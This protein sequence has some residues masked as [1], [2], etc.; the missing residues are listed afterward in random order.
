MHRITYHQPFDFERSW[1]VHCRSEEGQCDSSG[2]FA[3]WNEGRPVIVTLRQSRR[4]G[5]IEVELEPEPA[6]PRV[7]LN[8]IRS[9]LNAD[10]DLEAFYR[11]ARRDALMR[12]VT[13]QLRGLKPIRPADLFQMMVIAITEQ[14]ISMAAA[15]RIRER[16]VHRFGTRVKDL[17]AFPQPSDFAGCRIDDLK[18][19]G[20]SG[21]KAKYVLEL[22]GRIYD[23][24]LDP[25][26]W[27]RLPREDLREILL[28]LPGVG[29]WTVSY[30]MVRGLGD[31]DVVPS[32]DL[33]VRRIVGKYL[34]NG[35]PVSAEE[36]DR[37]LADW[38]PWRGLVVFYLLVLNWGV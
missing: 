38:S 37:L 29:E 13:G 11:I 4:P 7:L 27:S 16:L 34:G 14:Q 9:M 28:E 25:A 36:V 19:V 2:R 22:A 1:S 6:Q 31:A 26:T 32:T 21:Q 15:F 23:G 20:L 17:I 12:K 30:L 35:E 10:L 18:A 33:G 8:S 3:S 24:S 5:V